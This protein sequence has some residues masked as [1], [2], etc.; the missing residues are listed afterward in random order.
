MNVSTWTR[1]EL[2]VLRWAPVSL[3][4]WLRGPSEPSLCSVFWEPFL[5]LF[6]K[7]F[8]FGWVLSKGW[9]SDWLMWLTS[10]HTVTPLSS[11]QV[12]GLRLHSS[13]EDKQKPCPCRRVLLMCSADRPHPDFLNHRQPDWLSSPGGAQFPTHVAHRGK[14]CEHKNVTLFSQLSLRLVF[15]TSSPPATWIKVLYG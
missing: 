15:W 11:S 6:A 1:R 9:G 3:S 8:L 13:L 12:L 10:D 7:R 4:A 14:P 5:E 2:S